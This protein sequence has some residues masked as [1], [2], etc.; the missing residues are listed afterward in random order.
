MYICISF[1]I[2]GAFRSDFPKTICLSYNCTVNSVL[3]NY[4][5]YNYTIL[6]YHCSYN[7]SIFYYLFQKKILE[8]SLGGSIG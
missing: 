8:G 7:I 5:S 2:H 3:Y 4:L 1:V 6:S